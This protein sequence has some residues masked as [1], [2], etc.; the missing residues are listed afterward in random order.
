MSKRNLSIL[1]IVIMSVT[2]ACTAVGLIPDPI[3]ETQIAMEATEDA[4]MN[5]PWPTEDNSENGVS[6][7]SADPTP[8]TGLEVFE[9]DV[10]END[11]LFPEVIVYANA[12]QITPPDGYEVSYP[13][14][15]DSQPL[16]NNWRIILLDGGTIQVTTSQP[17]AC[18][19][20]IFI[21][22]YIS[23][24]EIYINGEHKWGGYLYPPAAGN[25]S[26]AFYVRIAVEPAQ[27]ITIQVVGHAP[28]GD[29]NNAYVPVYAFGFELP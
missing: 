15:P 19:G 3:G 27:P 29:L 16:N 21:S 25:P 14:S 5:P 13:A 22:D 24:A 4:Y 10:R 8:C 12:E 18:A 6:V 9:E 2:L 23:P 7:Q 26:K 20:L 28:G 1:F 11:A 17:V